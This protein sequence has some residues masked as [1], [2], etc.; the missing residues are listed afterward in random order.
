MAFEAVFSRDYPSLQAVIAIM[1][2]AIIVIN[3]VVD[4]AYGLIDPRI[5]VR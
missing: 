2:V 3:L 1:A 4:I 5:R